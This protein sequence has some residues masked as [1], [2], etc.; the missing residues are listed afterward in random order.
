LVAYHAHLLKTGNTPRIRRE[1]SS[2]HP[3]TVRRRAVAAAIGFALMGN[4][5]GVL[6]PSPSPTAT[7]SPTPTSTASATPSPSPSPTAT[8]APPLSL[9]LP[10]TQDARKIRFS[11]VPAVPTAKGRGKVTVSISNLSTTM[12]KEIVLRWPTPLDQTVFMAPFS[13]SAN[14]LRGAL[15]Q[16]WTKWVIGP[17][18][19]GEP[20]G[21]TSLGWGPI[22]PGTTLSFEVVATRRAV[23]AVAFDLQLLAGEAVLSQQNGSP[24]ETRV[25]IR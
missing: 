10:P 16:E 9:D 3:G 24:A 22:L 25:S 5:C 1:R 7:A 20:A 14:R 6:T 21:T 8:P 12:I 15:V 2:A 18:E 13:P 11:V 19:S 23:G 4:A 17:G